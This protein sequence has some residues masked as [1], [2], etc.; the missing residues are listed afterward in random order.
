MTWILERVE[1]AMK[2]KKYWIFDLIILLILIIV[3]GY[4][5][6]QKKKSDEI[7][8]G[9]PYTYHY[10]MIGTVISMGEENQIVV[11]PHGRT[12]DMDF[13][14]RKILHYLNEDEVVLEYNKTAESHFNAYDGDITKLQ[15]G[16]VIYFCCFAGEIDKRPIP[17]NSVELLNESE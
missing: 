3:V 14:Y 9:G 10:Y 16:D 17:V 6:I 1:G 2:K 4:F 11:R 13:E 8:L 12:E 5:Y 15:E 7:V